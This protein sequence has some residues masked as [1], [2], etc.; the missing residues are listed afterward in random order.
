MR[1]VA[2]DDSTVRS[3]ALRFLPPGQQEWRTGMV[4]IPV[5]PFKTAQAFFDQMVATTPDANTGKVD[6]AKMQA[7]S[8]EHPE[9]GA[10]LK[11]V[12]ART[13]SS[14]FGDST[15]NSLD[16]FTFVDVNGKSTRVR[17]AAFPVTVVSSTPQEPSKDTNAL[18][19][20]FIRQVATRPV[21]WHLVITVGTPEDHTDDPTVPWP[22]TRKQVDAGIVS[23]DHVSSE[24]GGPCIDVNY[25]PLVLPSGI[26]ASDDPIP[27]ARSAAY[28]RSFTLREGERTVKPPSA[29]T[30]HEYNSGG[31]HEH[32]EPKICVSRTPDSL[33]NGGADSRH[34]V[35]WDRDGESDVQSLWNAR[36]DSQAAGIP[37]SDACRYS[38]GYSPDHAASGVACRSRANPASRSRV[39]ARRAVFV[40]VPFAASGLG[41][42]IRR[43]L[44]NRAVRLN[45]ADANTSEGAAPLRGSQ[46]ATHHSRVST[47]PNVPA[48]PFG[49]VVPCYR[50]PG[51]CA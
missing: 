10:A 31:S 19:D 44:P 9:F 35:D 38:T 40:D 37:D 7:F 50:A 18:F 4:N 11:I 28:S 2:D 46:R 47:V 39:V 1:F 30:P 26:E 16:T 12:G 24:D 43:W 5:F 6:P 49:G 20:G 33:A 45:R 23:L 41:N 8:A 51:W 25:D 29:V 13:V 15:Y 32:S 34:V 27:S 17:W 48:A 14:G 42:A 3:L 22:A 36:C 21:Q